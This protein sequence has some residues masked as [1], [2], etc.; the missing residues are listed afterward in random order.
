LEAI[1]GASTRELMGW[2]GHTSRSAVLI[3]QHRTADRG[4]AIADAMD[5]MLSGGGGPIGDR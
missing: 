1:T 2:T 3:Y 4:R 5:V